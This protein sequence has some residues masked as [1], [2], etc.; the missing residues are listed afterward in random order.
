MDRPDWVGW[1]NQSRQGWDVGGGAKKGRSF[2]Q[3]NGRWEEEEKVV[4][5]HWEVVFQSS[6]VIGRSLPHSPGP[7]SNV[8]SI[9]GIGSCRTELL[10]CPGLFGSAK[11]VTG[12]QVIHI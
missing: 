11:G 3:G 8:S 4:K 12:T 10:S 6:V 9:T 5:K 2:G 7:M 1:V